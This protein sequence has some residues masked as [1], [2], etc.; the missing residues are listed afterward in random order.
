MPT[1]A[2]ATCLEPSHVTNGDK[3]RDDHGE[4]AEQMGGRCGMR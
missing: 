1:K 3:Q 4:E 2:A